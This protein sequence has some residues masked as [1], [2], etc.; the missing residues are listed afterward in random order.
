MGRQ[1]RTTA[2]VR[3]EMRERAN[4]RKTNRS[5]NDQHLDYVSKMSIKTQVIGHRGRLNQSHNLFQKPSSANIIPCQ[6]I[7][8]TFPVGHAS[9]RPAY[10]VQGTILD[11]ITHQVAGFEP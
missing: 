2:N 7:G 4:G 6:R 1:K 3:V 11:G 10:E 8:S 9:G 5:A